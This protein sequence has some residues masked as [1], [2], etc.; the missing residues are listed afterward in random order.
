MLTSILLSLGAL[1]SFLSDTA[2]WRPLHD[3][4][5]QMLTCNAGND[6]MLWQSDSLMWLRAKAYQ[7]RHICFIISACWKGGYRLTC[8]RSR[9]ATCQSSRYLR[10]G[11]LP[12]KQRLC[13]FHNLRMATIGATSWLYT[14]WKE[15]TFLF[16]STRPPILRARATAFQS[17][18]S[19][20]H[21]SI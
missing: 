16:A 14:S 3:F 17:Y 19:L 11:P 18:P 4:L 8:R 20:L 7:A 5:G 6:H 12:L 2:I 1:R 15:C 10:S 21:L 13:V 9:V